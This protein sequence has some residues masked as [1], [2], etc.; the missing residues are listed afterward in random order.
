MKKD[1]LGVAFIGCGRVS[2]NHIRAIAQNC[3]RAR[4]LYVCDIVPEKAEKARRLY[5]EELKACGSQ[6]HAHASAHA[7]P[8]GSPA[9]AAAATVAAID[10]YRRALDDP[11]VDMVTIATESGYHAEM[12]LNAL[13]AGKHVLVE[14][15]IAL[16]TRDAKRM[17]ALAAE[18]KLRLGVCHQ[19]RFNPPVQQLRKA[20]DQKLLGKLIYGTINVRWYR[21]DDYYAAEAWRGTYA[22]DGGCLMNQCIH[23]I[24]LLLWMMGD[25]ERV[26]AESG[27][28][29]HPIEA[30]DTA[31]A[32]LRFRNGA[33]GIIEGTTCVYPANL[34]ET[35]NIF[36]E[37]GTCCLG[38]MAV[39]KVEHF[40]VSSS[41]NNNGHIN[42]GHFNLGANQAHTDLATATAAA[43]LN[44]IYG[45]GHTPLYWDFIDAVFSGRSPAV[46]GEAGLK[47]I[48]MVLGI[49]KSAATGRPVEWPLGDYSTLEAA[50][51]LKR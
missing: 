32:A 3:N 17:I 12:A 8:P 7:H 24:D 35:L 21:G 30:E 39:N 22:L 4:L 5:Y 16:D 44:P 29:L 36:G 28:F 49:Y 19:N 18:K 20:L 43:P 2:P 14:K 25:A 15:P 34:E 1:K 50:A 37:K 48:E 27:T 41:D 9:A 45:K 6:A 11:A 38:G 51:D 42:N 40:I 13:A 33:L 26:Y 10:D 23:G 31:V 46:D 47:A